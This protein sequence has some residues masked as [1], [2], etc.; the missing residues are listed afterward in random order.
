MRGKWVAPGVGRGIRLSAAGSTAAPGLRRR[1]W[2]PGPPAP[3]AAP[4]PV[5]RRG[6]RPRSPSSSGVVTGRLIL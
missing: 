2:T 1:S 4:R 6:P 3:A 5:A